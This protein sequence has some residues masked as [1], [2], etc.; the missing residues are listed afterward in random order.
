MEKQSMAGA[1]RKKRVPGTG[2]GEILSIAPDFDELPDDFKVPLDDYEALEET[3]Y[4][5]RNPKNVR[6]LME[7]I[8]ELE[9]GKTTER[10]LID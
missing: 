1:K 10:E 3:A 4:L 6:R 2:K 9:S 5:L 7:S 8:A